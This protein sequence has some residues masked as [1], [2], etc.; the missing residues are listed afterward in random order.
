MSQQKTAFIIDSD[1]EL[2]LKIAAALRTD[3]LNVGLSKDD[4]DPL[5]EMRLERADIVVVCADGKNSESGFS[6][7]NRLKKSRRW[8]KTPVVLYALD[9]DPTRLDKHREQSTPADGYMMMPKA[10][11]YPLEALRDQVKGILFPVGGASVP[12]PL[13]GPRRPRRRTRPGARPGAV[14][15]RSGLRAP[16]VHPRTVGPRPPR[17]LK[18]GHREQII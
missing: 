10:P 7:C 12:P 11:P 5:E 2:A 17:E 8:S 1:R 4:Q 3:G 14:R 15:S 6:I 18:F 16:P 13:P 9:E